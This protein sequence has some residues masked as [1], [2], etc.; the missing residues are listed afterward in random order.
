MQSSVQGYATFAQDGCDDLIECL[1]QE[2]ERRNRESLQHRLAVK[3]KI[4]EVKA[5]GE[6]ELVAKGIGI[7]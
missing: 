2:F 7:I 6:F 1:R 3:G 4:F 5:G